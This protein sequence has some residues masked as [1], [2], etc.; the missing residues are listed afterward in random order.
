M[1]SIE[2]VNGQF[3]SSSPHQIFLIAFMQMVSALGVTECHWHLLWH[4]VSPIC[5]SALLQWKSKVWGHKCTFYCLKSA[6]CT[7]TPSFHSFEFL[8]VSNCLD[9]PPLLSLSPTLSFHALHFIFFPW[10]FLVF[11]HYRGCPQLL[12]TAAHGLDMCWG[13]MSVW[14]NL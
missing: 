7:P 6:W 2:T 12:L 10:H 3:S 8:F 4:T 13:C 14:R 1:L 5:L 9:F 11:P